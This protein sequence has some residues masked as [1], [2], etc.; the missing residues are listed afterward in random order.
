MMLTSFNVFSNLGPCNSGRAH[1]A[2]IIQERVNGLDLS[3]Q[4]QERFHTVSMHEKVPIAILKARV[5]L[6]LLNSFSKHGVV[7]EC[8]YERIMAGSP[9]SEKTEI[10]II[11]ETKLN[12]EERN[13]PIRCWRLGS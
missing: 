8:W 4:L 5:L 3:V 6:I 11:Q 13:W 2:T 7:D 12:I 10:R 1:V 9:F